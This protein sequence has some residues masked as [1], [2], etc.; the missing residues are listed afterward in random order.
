[1]PAD[2]SQTTKPQL[3]FLLAPSVKLVRISLLTD[4]GTARAKNGSPVPLEE[5]LTTKGSGG[6]LR[7]IRTRFAHLESH[8]SW[9]CF[10][11]ELK[12]YILSRARAVPEGREALTPAEAKK[13]AWENGYP[14]ESVKLLPVYYTPGG[15]RRYLRSDVETF[16]QGGINFT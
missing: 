5:I 8:G 3:R 6:V 14:G 2:S 13:L 15:H 12:Q 9:F 16:S 11:G 7:G 10:E 1:M 4:Q